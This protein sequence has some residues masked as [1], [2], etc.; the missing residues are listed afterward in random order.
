M[1]IS[2]E[3]FLELQELEVQILLND[4]FIG[5]NVIEEAFPSICTLGDENVLCKYESKVTMPESQEIQESQASTASNRKPSTVQYPGLKKAVAAVLK[6]KKKD[7]GN[8]L[9]R[10]TVDDYAKAAVAA[11][12]WMNPG[13]KPTE[14]D[15]NLGWIE[16]D[17]KKIYSYIIDNYDSVHTRH[18][19]VTK[20]SALAL[21]FNLRKVNEYFVKKCMPTTKPDRDA[22]YEKGIV[23]PSVKKNFKRYEELENIV[24]RDL[25]PPFKLIAE[26]KREIYTKSEWKIMTQALIG[27]LNVI[28]PCCRDALRYVKIVT[29]EPS[30]RR[31]KKAQRRRKK[32]PQHN[33][34]WIKP[35]GIVRLYINIDKVIDTMGPDQWDLPEKTSK[36]VVESLTMMPRNFLFPRSI[37]EDAQMSEDTYTGRI[38]KTFG[39]E[40]NGDKKHAGDRV[41]RHAQASFFFM[42]YCSPTLE[43]KKWLARRLRHSKDIMEL[44]YRSYL[45][46][47]YKGPV[48]LSELSNEDVPEDTPNPSQQSVQSPETPQQTRQKKYMSKP[49]N[50]EAQRERM[51]ERYQVDKLRL[52]ARQNFYKWS[53]GKATPTATSLEKFKDYIGK[54]EDGTFYWKSDNAAS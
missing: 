42:K 33:Y 21:H 46:G 22:H 20:I 24:V 3:L 45:D 4:H 34:M 37:G 18:G 47:V 23:A 53:A 14:S 30:Q 49:A 8:R 5:D 1:Q 38:R 50:Q 9:A 41:I 40:D 25:L 39:F 32:K 2:D 54:R 44:V 26:E 11:W 35:D 48:N 12:K 43:Q 17:Y 10:T 52:N 28:E 7:N 36:V 29:E 15:Y 13:Q 16:R 51:R 27:V 6:T 19:H 31:L